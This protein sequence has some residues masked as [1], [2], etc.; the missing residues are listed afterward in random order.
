MK[1]I[2]MTTVIT[3]GILAANGAVLSY[4][5]PDKK[6]YVSVSASENSGITDETSLIAFLDEHDRTAGTQIRKEDYR[7]L[8]E[9][10]GPVSVHG[11]YLI[12][13][14]TEYCMSWEYS[15]QTGDAVLERSKCFTDEPV[16]TGADYDIMHIYKAV[17]PGNVKLDI[18]NQNM[19]MENKLLYTLNLS[20]DEDLNITVTD[21]G[22][23]SDASVSH[24]DTETAAGDLNFD[25][26]SDLTDLTEL[27]L[28]LIGDETLSPEQEKAADIDDD[29]KVSLAD[30]AR[31]RQFLSKQ[32]ESL[33]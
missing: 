10:Y 29:G 23:A 19:R 17:E 18:Y 8:T 6:D 33:K 7:N 13:C 32:I 30:L 4:N 3:L 15:E 5:T 2:L 12:Y 22:K 1:K 24:D 9:E 31:F 11:K 16:P 14:H 26:V 25:G 20:V 28:S 27:S 21:F